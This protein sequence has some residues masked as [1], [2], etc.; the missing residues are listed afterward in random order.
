MAETVALEVAR[1]AFLGVSSVAS[2]TF[3]ADIFRSIS[4]PCRRGDL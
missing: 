4:S 3:S 1:V 2:L